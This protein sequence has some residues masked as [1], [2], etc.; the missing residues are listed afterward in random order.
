MFTQTTRTR[1]RRLTSN[2]GRLSSATAHHKP[3]AKSR[4][5]GRILGVQQSPLTCGNMCMMQRNMKYSTRRHTS[6]ACLPIPASSGKTTPAAHK[7]S[8]LPNSTFLLK[9]GE[10]LNAENVQ[11]CLHSLILD[12]DMTMMEKRHRSA[13]WMEP[14]NIKSSRTFGCSMAIT[15]FR[16]SFRSRKRTKTYHPILPIQR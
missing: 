2:A 15:R 4:T 1:Y 12:T 6:I 7:P 9:L 5:G 14:R 10:A 16:R 13:W 11:S 3:E 8:E